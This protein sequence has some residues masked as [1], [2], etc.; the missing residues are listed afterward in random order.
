VAG[1]PEFKRSIGRMLAGLGDRTDTV[2][3]D[4]ASIM[5]MNVIVGGAYASGTPVDTGFARGSW[6]P[7]INGKPLAE[8]IVP[9]AVSRAIQLLSEGKAGDRFE[10]WTNTSYMPSLEYGHSKQAPRGMVRLTLSAAQAIANEAIGK[11]S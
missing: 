4:M 6:Y 7:A 1:A 3:R 10:L 11:L 8:G 5:A 2:A 9:D